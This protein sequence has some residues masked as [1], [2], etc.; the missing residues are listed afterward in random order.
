MLSQRTIGGEEALML[1]P[2]QEGTTVRVVSELSGVK[3]MLESGLSIADAVLPR[4]AP[5]EYDRL[6]LDL[7]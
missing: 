3:A 5:P 2:D 1:T 6:S 7:S 4:T